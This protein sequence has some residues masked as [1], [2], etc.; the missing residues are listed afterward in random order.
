M[1]SSSKQKWE[2]LSPYFVIEES[3]EVCQCNFCYIA[4]VE[5]SAKDYEQA[6]KLC[7]Y[8][9]SAMQYEDANTAID[10]LTKALRLLSTGKSW[11]LY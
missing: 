7:K 9:I 1:G 8:A 2:E 4:G 10:N 5:L 11:K 6:T 3:A